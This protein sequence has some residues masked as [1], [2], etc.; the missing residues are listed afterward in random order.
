M[1]FSQYIKSYDMPRLESHYASKCVYIVSYRS[2]STELCS[3]LSNKN[4]TVLILKLVD[5]EQATRYYLKQRWLS[6][7][8]HI[9]VTRPRWVN[10]CRSNHSFELWALCLIFSL[11]LSHGYRTQNIW[12]IT[13]N[14]LQRVFVNM[15]QKGNAEAVQT[16]TLSI[17][18]ITLYHAYHVYL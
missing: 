7:Y 8:A 9:C 10:L 2:K 13:R 12:P 1:R 16:L 6:L 3:Q 14:S 17:V 4:I 18:M 11:Q 15:S 5:T